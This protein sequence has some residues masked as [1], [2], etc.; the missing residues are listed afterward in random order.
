MRSRFP[1]WIIW[2]TA[3]IVNEILGILFGEISGVNDWLSAGGSQKMKFP[4]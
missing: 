3:L 1:G 2:G 4:V